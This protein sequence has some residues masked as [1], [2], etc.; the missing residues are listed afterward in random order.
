MGENTKL[1]IEGVNFVTEQVASARADVAE[2]RKE[3]AQ[4]REELTKRELEHSKEQTWWL[5][6]LVLAAILGS[7]IADVITGIIYL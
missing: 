4:H 5:I 3:L 7:I 6:F 1:T 2:L